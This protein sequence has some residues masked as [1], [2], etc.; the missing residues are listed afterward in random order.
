VDGVVK[1]KPAL[2]VK[3]M[4]L[5]ALDNLVSMINIIDE[6]SVR[7]VLV[8]SVPYDVEKTFDKTIKVFGITVMKRKYHITGDVQGVTLANK[9]VGFSTNIDKDNEKYNSR[10][11]KEKEKA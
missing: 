6:K 2:I 5:N 4:I 9:I 10:S 8:N 7:T 1:K 11:E 3:H